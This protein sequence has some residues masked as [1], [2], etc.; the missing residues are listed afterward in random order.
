MDDRQEVLCRLVPLY[1]EPLVG[2]DEGGSIECLLLQQ[3]VLAGGSN[4]QQVASAFDHIHLTWTQ[5]VIDTCAV[6]RE[7][8]AVAREGCLVIAQCKVVGHL[9]AVLLLFLERFLQRLHLA[10]KLQ[11]L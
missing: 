2:G 7:V 5:V 10:C 11:L 4:L 3:E 9:C 6:V 8:P 1:R